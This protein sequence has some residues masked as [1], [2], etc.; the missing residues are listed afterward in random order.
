M[1]RG[2]FDARIT[3]G[4]E[5]GAKE[6]VVDFHVEPGPY[7]HPLDMK[8]LCSCLFA[9]RRESERRGV[10]DFQPSVDESGAWSIERGRSYTVGRI[11]FTG[12]RH[13]S[14]G[15]I[16]S[17]FLLDEGVPLDSCRLRQS[18]VRLNRSAML[19]PLVE[20]QI[21]LAAMAAPG[22]ADITVNLT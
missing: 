10:L 20:H 13:Y 19:E 11:R 2:H 4:E 15:V 18:V 8:A 5:L 6:A 12:H 14:D 7:Y 16:R 21:H 22:V 17:Q 1:P 9:E 3:A